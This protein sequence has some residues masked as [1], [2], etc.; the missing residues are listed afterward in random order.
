MKVSG[1]AFALSTFSV[2]TSAMPKGSGIR[3]FAW[4]ARMRADGARGVL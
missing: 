1:S 4:Y 3:R 2:V